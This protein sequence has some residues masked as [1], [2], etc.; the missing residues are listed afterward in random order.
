MIEIRLITEI[1]SSKKKNS[2]LPL[3]IMSNFYIKQITRLL[4]TSY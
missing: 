3:N 2:S 1:D 4:T